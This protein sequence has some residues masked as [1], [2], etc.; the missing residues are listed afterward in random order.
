MVKSKRLWVERRDSDLRMDGAHMKRV[1]RLGLMDWKRSTLGNMH[2][3]LKE[4][5]AQ[6]DA[7]QQGVITNDSKRKI[8]ILAKE[9][10]RLR[11]TNDIYW[12][13][14]EATKVE[15]C[16][17]ISILQQYEVLSGH[18]VNPQKS[19]VMFSP[20]V[21]KETRE[22]ISRILGMPEVTSHGSYLGLP[23]TIDTSKREVFSSIVGRVKSRIEDWKPKI[24]SKLPINTCHEINPSILNYWW[25]ATGN[26]KNI[27]WVA[28]DKFS[29]DKAD[30]GL[31]FRDTHA[32]NMALLSKQAWRIASDPPS[33]LAQNEK[34]KYFPLGNFWNATIG[35]SPSLTWKSLLLARDLLIKDTKWTVYNG[36]T[37]PVWNYR[38]LPHTTLKKPI[39][40]LNKDYADMRV[41]DL[42]DSE[43]GVWNINL[44][45]HLFF[46]I[47]ADVILNRDLCFKKMWKLKIPEKI[48]HFLWKG[49]T[50]SLPTKD[51]LSKK[52]I[53]LHPSCFLCFQ[54]HE[55]KHIFNT[56]MCAQKICKELT[57]EEVVGDASSFKNLFEKRKS[58]LPRDKFL[59]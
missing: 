48:K 35:H 28:Y 26:K 15:A 46:S 25:G 10:D 5:Q 30:G 59:I 45:R 16:S 6:L 43:V 18:L 38:W 40:P 4:K 1:K 32:F 53:D 19:V 34:A 49:L 42:I 14:R 56:C 57:I 23:S 50:K 20:N 11:G 39:T 12:Q 55:S 21:K 44:V 9:I 41:C 33:Q 51:N 29:R 8:V 37:I 3:S 24:L 2:N 27:H 52:K 13:Q 54:G 36:R 17:I 22:A 31:G 7:L 58:R 47:D